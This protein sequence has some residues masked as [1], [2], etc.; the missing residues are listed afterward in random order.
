MEA[1]HVQLQAR[2]KKAIRNANA[3]LLA[4]LSSAR[5]KTQSLRQEIT[6]AIAASEKSTHALIADMVTRIEGLPTMVV[7]TRTQLAPSGSR[8]NR[9]YSR[10]PLRND[11]SG[12]V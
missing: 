9:P 3:Q 12:D 6:D 10:P 8:R 7:N 2:V 4:A 5:Q 1:R 11:D